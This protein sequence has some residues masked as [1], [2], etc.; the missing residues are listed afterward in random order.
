[1]LK[2][3]VDATPVDSK[4]SGVGFYIANLICALDVLQKEENFQLGVV[5]QPGLKNWLRGDFI[6][7][8][9]FKNSSQQYLLPLPVRVSDLLLALAFK[10]SLSYF[11]K[12]FGYPDILHGTNYSVYPCQNSL[13]VMNIYDLTFIKYPNYTDSVVKT[14]TKRV[15][16]CLQWTDL[17]LT[18]SES[19]KK[20]I[21]EYLQVDPEKVYVTPLASRY[22]P[23]YLSEEVAQILEKQANYDFSKPYLLFV[24]TIEPR[25]NINNIITAFNLLKEKYKI[26]HQLILIGRKGWNYEPIFAAIEN[27]PWANQ[28]HHLNYLSN[29]LVALFYSKADVFVYPSHYEGFGLPVLEAMT[30]G[31]PVISSNTSSIPE[32]TGDA[33]ILVD[34]NNPIELGEA[35]LKVISDSQLRQELINKGKARAKLFS[36]E[37][38]AKETLNAYRTII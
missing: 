29:E 21:I 2:V 16:R 15:K 37:R 8:E 25:K 3:V 31:V 33:A 17:V 10:P 7:P 36:W 4:P 24:S 26:E 30:L 35:I 13:K 12:Y 5:Y 20:D 23:N 14:Y 34:P 19:S 22:Y 6:V 38:T 28:I 1:M 9:C 11:E 27:S 32:V 18:I